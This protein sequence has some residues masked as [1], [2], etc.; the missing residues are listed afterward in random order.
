[1]A[2][3]GAQPRQVAARALT[4]VLDGGRALDTALAPLLE[5][6]GEARDRALARRL[7]HGVL[8]DWPALDWLIARLLA[9]PLK[10]RNRRL[11]FLM[12]VALHEL[13]DGREPEHA[14]VHAAV[15]AARS[16]CGPRL[17]GLV[18]G[19]LRNF[20]RRRESLLVDLPDTVGFRFGYPGW[21]VEAIEA[22]R[23]EAT[24]GI[25][26]AG[27][28]PPPLWL[29]VNRR[30]SAPE[31]YREELA[32]AGIEAQPV[33][34]FADAL[35]L[36]ERIAVRHLPGFE[37]GLVSIQDGAAQLA[38]D[39]LELE[40]GQRVLD[41]CA[42]PG[43]K[44]AHILERA[45][46]ELTALDIDSERLGRVGNGLERLGLEARLVEGDAARPESWWNGEGFDRILVDAPCSATGV[47]RRHPDI[48]WLRRREDIERL[49]ATQR[50]ILDALWPLLAP[51]GI[52]VYATCSLMRVENDEQ[53]RAFLERHADA[54]AIDNPDIPGRPARPG[55]QVLPGERDCD[56]FYYLAAQR[57]S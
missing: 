18:N 34:G 16:L 23:G 37:E 12:A 45:A 40:D 21:L 14:V 9:K 56:G 13:R 4:A 10:G 22:D 26:A 48:R 30:R 32:Q 49:V 53:A 5:P 55:R 1:M 27:N 15:A 46:V 3:D 39:Y 25:L 29:R 20:G 52:L 38:A 28:E 43:G 50:A 2:H 7:C 11:H 19:V 57:V 36:A 47:I 31:A 35:V 41:A 8:R 44:A 42:A 33:D 6:L 24:P 51:G 17:A 54:R